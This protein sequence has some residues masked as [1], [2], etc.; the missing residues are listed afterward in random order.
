MFLR[1]EDGIVTSQPI[2]GTRP[3]GAT[4]DE[5]A[6]EAAALANSEKD[7]AELNMIVDLVRND[8]GRVC[9]YGT[10]QVANEGAIER[11]P[12]VFHRAATVRGRLRSDCDAFDL[13][14]AA[15]PGG[16]ITGAPKVRAM[17]LIH[18]FETEARG[19]YCGAIGYIGLDG[20]MALN[21]PIRTL[22][23]ADGWL[24]LKVGS[25]IV[26]D[27]VPVEEYEELGAK[28]AGMLAAI[29]ADETQTVPALTQ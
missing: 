5:D 21:L 27:S 3:R 10:V 1:L 29:G 28:A 17:Q 24:D 4:P 14:R 18:E 23:M 25:G 13:L 9:T 7:Q 6:L 8:L 22:T 15:F 12:T 19:P 2:K 16:S 20:N 11:H 26:A